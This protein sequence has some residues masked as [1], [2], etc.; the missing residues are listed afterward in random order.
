MI[1]ANSKALGDVLG[2]NY[3]KIR[4]F[5]HTETDA[6]TCSAI[7]TYFGM[8]DASDQQK[9]HNI[10]K[11]LKDASLPEKQQWFHDQVYSMLDTFVM[12]SVSSLKDNSQDKGEVIRGCDPSCNSA[13]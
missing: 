4:E 11:G 7:M 1:T 5:F 12:D 6:F 2:E 10:P 3:D 8:D 9:E 13:H